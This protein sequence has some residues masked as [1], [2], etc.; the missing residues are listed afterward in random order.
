MVD[1]KTPAWVTKKGV[2]VVLVKVVAVI[3][4]ESGARITV[5]EIKRYESKALRVGAWSSSIL[6]RNWWVCVKNQQ[7]YEVKSSARRTRHEMEG[8]FS[9]A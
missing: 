8:I 2:N 7:G 5:S 4:E 6:E 1:G 9:Y 3:S